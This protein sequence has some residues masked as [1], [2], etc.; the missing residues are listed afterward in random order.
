M[1]IIFVKLEA[2]VGTVNPNKKQMSSMSCC[3]FAYFKDILNM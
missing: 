1:S 2:K 3:Y